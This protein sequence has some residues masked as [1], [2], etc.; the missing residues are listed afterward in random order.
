MSTL[1]EIAAGARELLEPSDTVTKDEAMARPLEHK[2]ETL[3]IYPDLGRCRDIPFQTG[4][5]VRREFVLIA[6]FLEATSEEALQVRNPDVT[7]TLYE[8][9]ERWLTA[10]RLNQSTTLWHHI[11]AALRTPPRILGSRAIALE[12]SGYELVG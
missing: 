6:E 4:P 9:L 1:P 12:I 11:Q 3:Y 2:P 7:E 8:R 5:A 10:V